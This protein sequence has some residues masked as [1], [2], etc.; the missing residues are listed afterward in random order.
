MYGH[1]YSLGQ[2]RTL[3]VRRRLTQVGHDALARAHACRE[4][5]PPV[6]ERHGD[7]VDAAAVREPPL[8]IPPAGPA[9]RPLA[10]PLGFLRRVPA[11][12]WAGKSAFSSGADV[13]RDGRAQSRR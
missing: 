3:Q 10:E 12:M 9:P 2:C 4:H 13:A 6:H 7:L 1:T 8:R 11:R 5:A